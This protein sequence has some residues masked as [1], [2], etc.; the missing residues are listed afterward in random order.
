MREVQYNHESGKLP[1]S[2]AK[3]PLFKQI[4]T[5]GLDE[6]LFNSSLVEYD[7]GE[8]VIRQGE[9]GGDMFIL[10]K[11]IVQVTVDGKPVTML[12]NAGELLGELAVLNKAAR[13]ATVV[14]LNKAFCLKIDSRFLN[15]LTPEDQSAFYLVLYRFLVEVLS[16]RLTET[17]KRLAE[18]EAGR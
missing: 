13:S 11:G 18:L 8:T 7:P 12:D 1:P 17:T 4:D 2:L 10:L 6:I 16:E 14:A 9:E 15:N 5:G 3:L